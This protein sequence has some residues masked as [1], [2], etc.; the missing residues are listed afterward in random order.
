MYVGNNIKMD[1]IKKQ[2]DSSGP[3]PVMGSCEHGDEPSGSK[4]CWEFLD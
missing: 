1:F 4:N 3:G 2:M